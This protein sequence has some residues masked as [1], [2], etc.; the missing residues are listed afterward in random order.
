[1]RAVGSRMTGA[2][3]GIMGGIV[4]GGRVRLV[5]VGFHGRGVLVHVAAVGRHPAE[6]QAAFESMAAVRLQV[7][8]GRRDKR[9]GRTGRREPSALDTG[10]NRGVERKR[11]RLRESKQGSLYPMRV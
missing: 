9:W 1:M 5:F 10:K 3:R 7:A 6:L 2:R 4:R 8:Q 11:E